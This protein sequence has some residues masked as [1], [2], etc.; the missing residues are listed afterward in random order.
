MSTIG[1]AVGCATVSVVKLAAWPVAGAD[2]VKLKPVPGST[3]PDGLNAAVD[4]V[5]AAGRSVRAA[6][7]RAASDPGLEDTADGAAVVAGAGCG[8]AVEGV[9][10]LRV[11]VPLIEKSR[12]WAGPTASWAAGGGGAMEMGALPE[13]APSS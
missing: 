4:A 8:N 13:D 3:V 7:S 6:T 5:V 12:S 2:G 1:A 9:S 11:T 10:A